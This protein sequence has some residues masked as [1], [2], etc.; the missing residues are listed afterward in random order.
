MMMPI[1]KAE[2]QSS[3]TF[4]LIRVLKQPIQTKIY[5]KTAFVYLGTFL[6]NFWGNPSPVQ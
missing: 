5:T 6:E 3:N 4:G 2:F 1:G